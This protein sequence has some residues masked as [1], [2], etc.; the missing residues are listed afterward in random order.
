MRDDSVQR[1]LEIADTKPDIKDQGDDSDSN[2]D[3]E[4]LDDNHYRGYEHETDRRYRLYLRDNDGEENYSDDAQP[5]LVAVNEEFELDHIPNANQNH[6]DEY[7]NRSSSRSFV[8]SSRDTSSEIIVMTQHTTEDDGRVVNSR[9]PKRPKLEPDP[10]VSIISVHMKLGDMS[11][12]IDL[13]GE[14]ETIH[15]PVKTG[16]SSME[17]I[18]LTQVENPIVIRDN[19]VIELIELEDQ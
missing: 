3:G 13:T 17:V 14:Q 7:D 15:E 12:F 5:N 19:S 11:G 10:E 8:P 2:F 1:R 16:S 6:F 4:Q 9:Y 18:D